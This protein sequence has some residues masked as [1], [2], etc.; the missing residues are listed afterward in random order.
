MTFTRHYIE[1]VV[2]MLLGMVL[3]GM[4]LSIGLEAVGID[5]GSWDKDAPALMLL[6]MAFTMSV[7]M[8]AW[9]RYR[10]HGWAPAGEMAAS[11]FIPSIVAIALLWGGLVEDSHSL[12]MIQ[13]VAML[14]AMLVA[15]VLR[16]SEYGG[17]RHAL[18]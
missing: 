14:P 8:V 12:L 1:M 3:L 16:R 5:V 15:M 6:G 2:A 9:M 7:P 11:M 18:A 10:G 17:H 4:P 13:H